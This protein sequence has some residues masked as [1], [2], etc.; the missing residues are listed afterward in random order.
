MKFAH[1][2]D[3]HIKNLKYHKE[4]KAVFKQLYASL[5][6][7][8]VDYIIHCGDIAH[9][10]TQ[11]SPEFVELCSDFLKNLADIAPTYIILGNHDGNLRNSY[12]QDAITPIVDALNH[13]NLHL[14]K[15]AGETHIDDKFCLNVLSVFD[16]D[17]WV[18]P[19]NPD[20]INIGL[21]HGAIKYSRTDIGFV[22][23]HGEHS[24]SIF[25]DCDYAMLGDIHKT[26]I[27]NKEG[28]IAYAGSTIQQNFGETDDKGMFIWDI[29]SKTEFSREKIN[30]V[31]PKPFITINLTKTGRIP[32]GFSCVDGARLRLVSKSNIPLERLRRAVDIAKHRFKPESITFLNKA[33]SGDLSVEDSVDT[34]LFEN[35]RDE[36][37][38]QDL[39][40]E[41]LKDYNVGE[42]TLNEVFALNSKYNKV[43]EES[44]DISRNVHWRIKKF[45][46][47]NLFNYGEGNSIDF[48]KLSGTVGIFGKNYSGKSSVIDALLY[49]VYNN[50]S[51]NIRKTYNIINQNKDYGSGLVEIE[52]NNKTY[53]ISR[54]SDKYTKKLKGKTTNE[55][56]T[57]ADFDY[58]DK[59]SGEVGSLN[60][61]ARGGTDKAI[62]NVFGDLDDF[63]NTSMSSQLGALGFINEGSTR[64]KEILAKFLDLEFFEKKFKLAKEDAADL[65]GALRRI[66]DVNYDDDIKKTKNDIFRAG[67]AVAKQKSLCTELKD[68]L[69]SVSEEIAELEHKLAQIPEDPISIRKVR[70]DL[71]RLGQDKKSLK[72]R[73]GNLTNEIKDKEG[74]LEKADALLETIDILNLNKQKEEADGLQDKI[75]S[76]LREQQKKE[77]EKETSLRQIKILTDIPC[78]D[79]FLTSCK[80]IKDAHN[81]KQDLSIT[82]KVLSE[83][84]DKLKLNAGELSNIDVEKVG[85][86][87][88]NWTR[89][90]EKRK[91]E[92]SKLTNLNLDLER[93]NSAL[94]KLESEIKEL[95]ETADYYEEHKEVLENIEK[96]MS[97]LELA[98]TNKERTEQELQDCEDQIY[99]LVGK[100]GALE[101]KLENLKDLKAEKNRLN[102]EYSA[103]DLFLTCMHSNGIAFDVIKKALPVINT[104]IAKVLSNIVEFEV[105]FENSEN[106]LNILIKHPKH[107]PRQLETCSGAEKTLAAVA[108]RI[109][110]LNVSN[111]PKSNLFILDEPGTA[112]DAENMEGFVRILDLVKGYFD[113]TLLITHIE[114]LKDIVDMTIEISKTEDGYAYVNQ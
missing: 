6:E 22:M 55:A 86:T 37:T 5:K 65:R 52:A 93:T 79:K 13:K 32:N 29:Q 77:Q 44:E 63:L 58:V 109:A 105:F 11:I 101:Q 103:Y 85:S 8:K 61:T 31:N 90:T 35:L 94:Q 84:E 66:Q 113:V 24:I 110:L 19:T 106:K 96:V 98:K 59:V 104:E 75:D 7:Q 56:K 42:D 76:L 40:K 100:E 60:Q 3:T 69:S 45:S 12:R 34:E 28:T 9:T 16:E 72:N 102:T 47:D 111:M 114:S 97:E 4:Y 51:K 38:Q 54:R 70:K 67:A 46:W 26:Q 43:V 64:R 88:S 89:L 48:D 80:F 39:I 50:T 81:A 53:Q 21:Y 112:L 17:N 27:L 25:D 23:E 83:V 107:D 78:G 92:Q 33:N 68:N 1:I 95:N 2:A 10:K 74:F 73:I 41:Y 57:Q 36:K 49:T 14:L 108:I 30:F 71:E 15:D 18:K 91:D 82:K 20:K 62:R 99:T 87:I